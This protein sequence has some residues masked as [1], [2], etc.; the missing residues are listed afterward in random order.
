[1]DLRNYAAV[2]IFSEVIFTSEEFDEN[3]CAKFCGIPKEI[4]EV[5]YFGDMETWIHGDT[6]T[7]RH[8]YMETWRQLDMET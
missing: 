3:P 4:P 2:G 5:L 6:D 7:W 8:G 1:M